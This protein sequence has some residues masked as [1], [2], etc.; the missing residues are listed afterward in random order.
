MRAAD[1]ITQKKFDKEYTKKIMS[2]NFSK[3]PKEKDNSS[4][5]I[6]DDTYEAQDDENELDFPAKELPERKT[7][8][9]R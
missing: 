3:L 5:D 2:H 8:V 7:R 6:M 9:E 1:D 4:G